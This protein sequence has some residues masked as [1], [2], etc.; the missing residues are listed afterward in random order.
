[1]LLS[2]KRSSLTKV[3]CEHISS[4]CMCGNH[5][6]VWSTPVVMEERTQLIEDLEQRLEEIE[7]EK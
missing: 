7:I 5:W 6:E 1:M 4:C 2:K 3:S